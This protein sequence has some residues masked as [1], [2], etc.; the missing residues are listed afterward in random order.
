MKIR[1]EREREK[2]EHE[3]TFFYYCNYYWY[4][5]IKLSQFNRIIGFFFLSLPLYFFK[6]K[7]KRGFISFFRP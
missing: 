7:K 5:G 4:F 6:R 2:E 1:K 3:M